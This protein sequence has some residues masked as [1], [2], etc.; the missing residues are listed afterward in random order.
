MTLVPVY[1]DQVG[2]L[3]AQLLLRQ[4]FHIAGIC[5]FGFGGSPRCG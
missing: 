3:V 4:T 2:M 5:A 1:T